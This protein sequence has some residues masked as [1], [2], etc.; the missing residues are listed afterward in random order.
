MGILA[1][2]AVRHQSRYDIFRRSHMGDL[3][4]FRTS[5]L[6][7]QHEAEEALVRG[8]VGPR[9]QMWSHTDPSVSSGPWG[10]QRPG[11]TS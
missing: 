9:L 10:F 2:G 5:I 3:E 1:G 6:S 8:D 7:R 11:G 4:S